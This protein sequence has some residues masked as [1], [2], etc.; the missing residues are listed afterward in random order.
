MLKNVK[1]RKNT[2]KK[3]ESYTEVNNYKKMNMT[4]YPLFSTSKANTAVQSAYLFNSN[5][6]LPLQLH[7]VDC[8]TSSQTAIILRLSKQ[9]LVFYTCSIMTRIFCWVCGIHWR[10]IANSSDTVVASSYNSDSQSEHF[11]SKKGLSSLRHSAQSGPSVG[12]WTT[13]FGD[14]AAPSASLP[15]TSSITM[16]LV[17]ICD[18]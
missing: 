8:G 11:R 4:Y 9:Q 5:R 18:D 17:P 6:T 1:E 3:N 13:G 7:I 14:K 12:G 10:R 15:E 2:S 16:P